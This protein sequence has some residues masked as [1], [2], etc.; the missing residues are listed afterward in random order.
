MNLST[1][2]STMMQEIN[3]NRITKYLASETTPDEN[4]EIE[5]WIAEDPSRKQ[6]IDELRKMWDTSDYLAKVRSPEEM[7][8]ENDW[9]RLLKDM[10]SSKRVRK[11]RFPK[12]FSKVHDLSG[13]VKRRSGAWQFLRVAAVIIVMFGGAILLSHLLYSPEVYVEEQESHIREV[14]T[15]PSQLANITLRD[16]S[17]AR[18]G[19]DS[20][21]IISEGY[22]SEDR[23]VFVQGQVYFDVTHDHERP[24]IVE[25]GQARLEVLGTDFSVRAWPED[26]KIQVAVAGG[27]VSMSSLGNSDQEGIILREG[28]LGLLDK[29]SGELTSRQ[30][31]T[32]QYLSWLD[33]RIVFEDVK[34]H[35]VGRDLERWFDITID[36][37]NEEVA[38]RRLT[39]VLNNRSIDNVLDV[40]GVTLGIDY[41]IEQDSKLVI[42]K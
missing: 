29:V 14:F 10:R 6:E 36:F 19:V 26:E 12:G 7:E 42:I 1:S 17:V 35:Q 11:T 5:A 41:L 30:V 38:N 33:G 13:M 20:R 9:E 28:E 39:A 15:E 34:L 8:L 16:G 3:W 31:D 2:K 21:L 4:R 22:N 40:I 25:T 23:K 32:Q 24:F 27:S 18:L 37:Q